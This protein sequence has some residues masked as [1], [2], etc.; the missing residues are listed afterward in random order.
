MG[1][2]NYFNERE[3]EEELKLEHANVRQ[4]QQVPEDDTVIEMR[5]DNSKWRARMTSDR[6]ERNARFVET[7]D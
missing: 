6:R 5:S 2:A 3:V 7:S 1:V 4:I